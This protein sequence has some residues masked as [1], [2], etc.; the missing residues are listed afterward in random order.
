[1]KTVSSPGGSNADI[2][3][4]ART[5]RVLVVDDHEV[6]REGLRT[7][8]S[9]EPDISVVGGAQSGAEGIKKA[10]GLKPDIVLMDIKMPDMDGFA[11]ARK[12]M[13]Q[14]PDT[15][16]IMLTGYE[17]VLYVS[18]AVQVGVRGFV[19]K[20]CPRRLI[21]NA[22]RVV[23]DGGSVWEGDLIQNA[24]R[25][26]FHMHKIE[27]EVGDRHL[28]DIQLTQRELEI[29][30]LLTDGLTNKD[31]A[32]KLS[33]S[34]ETIKKSIKSIMGKLGVSNRTQAAIV[35]SRHSIV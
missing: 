25:G 22:V 4:G 8:L 33:I 3:G 34:V 14:Q 12:I 19:S 9:E 7:L 18:E 20:D 2:P 29:L 26:L 11:A 1:M 16:V 6:V 23:M 27:V 31:I 21:S 10:N 30:R 5:I 32:T 15:S 35:A 28:L 24:V 13:Q 17:S